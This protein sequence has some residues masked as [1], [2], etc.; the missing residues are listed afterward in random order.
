[1]AKPAR[2]GLV[3]RVP[4]WVQ[5]PPLTTNFKLTVNDR[6]DGRGELGDFATVQPR[7]WKGGDRVHLSYKLGPRLVTGHFGNSD[8]AALAWGPFVLAY[9]Q[10]VTRGCLRRPRSAWSARVRT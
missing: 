1:M 7:E 6:Q 4:K 9:D 2:F 5:V 10:R 8:R 3:V